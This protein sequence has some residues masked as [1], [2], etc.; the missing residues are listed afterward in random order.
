LPGGV[1][2][3][4]DFEVSPQTDAFVRELTACQ[5]VLR[6]YCEAALGPCED[7][8]DAWQQ[9]NV[10]LWRKATDWQIGSQF[11]PW[12]LAVARFEVLA[13][14]RDRQRE[15]LVF[16][17]DVAELMADEARDQALAG[18]FRRAAL[19]R[20]LAKLP[21]RQR[22]MLFAHYVAGASMAEIAAAQQ[23]GM[24]AVKVLLLRVRRS[25]ADCIGKHL[26]REEQA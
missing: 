10:T 12:A 15:R 26:P 4:V 22:G 7:A 17:S 11:L 3:Q 24:S 14:I 2:Q 5:A 9:T 21:D 6:G 19:E 8:K 25:L 20:C 16:D 13:V 23:M 1:E 18:G